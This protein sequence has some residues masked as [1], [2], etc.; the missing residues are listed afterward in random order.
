MPDKRIELGDRV[1]DR[2]TKRT[3]IVVSITDWLYGCRRI[4]IEPEKAKDG[5]FEHFVIDE[6][7]CQ[8]VKT[9]VITGRHHALDIDSRRHGARPDAARAPDPTRASD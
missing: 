6:P 3:G 8:L 4:Q 7:Q 9:H 2:I 5:K 1:K